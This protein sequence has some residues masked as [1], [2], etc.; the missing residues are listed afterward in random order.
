VA[1]LIFLVRFFRVVSPLPP[2]MGITLMVTTAVSAAVVGMDPGRVQQALRPLL[3]LQL[4][5]CSSG[6]LI[7][8]CRG[9]YDLLLTAGESRLRIAL[10]HWIMSLAPG[11]ACWLVVALVEAVATRGGQGAARTSGTVLAWA[12]VSSVPWAATVALPRFAGAIGWLLTLAVTAAAVPAAI[13]GPMF[14]RLG[15]GT[16]WVEAAVA[17]LVFPPL[18][19]G[20][21]VAGAQGWL[22]VPAL[23]VAVGSMVYAFGWIEHQD[24]PLEAAQ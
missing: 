22:A 7:P 4:F 18:V 2:L 9:H 17:I 15:A 11:A 12:L 1:R 16:S 19:V 14:E 20:E 8:A 5:A 3:L 13:D 6:F 23:I 21:D 24:I 10:V